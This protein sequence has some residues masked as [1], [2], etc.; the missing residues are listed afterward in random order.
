[1]ATIMT[2][3]FS[4]VESLELHGSGKVRDRGHAPDERPRT[5]EG[6][7]L[8][9]KQIRAR[10]R[11]RAK[12]GGR[13]RM[14]AVT[15]E[16]FEALYKPIEEWDLEELAKGRPRDINGKFTGATPNWIT[17]EVHEKAMELFQ[18]AIKGRMGEQ[19]LGALDT[20]SYILENDDVDHRGKPVIPANAKL[21]AAT[22]LL[23][24]V[25]GKP[26]QQIQQDISVKLQAILGSVMVN[27]NTALAPPSQGGYASQVDEPAYTL[28]HL[29]GHTIPMGIQET[30]EG[31]SQW[32]EDEDADLD[33]EAG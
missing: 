22:F 13:S 8:T 15:R 26:K 17:R 31:D 24:H 4:N 12:R 6:K 30:I 7:L 11:R 20:I 21:Q 9:P 16:E 2:V 10:A 18:S 25:V 19:S 33:Q 29:P 23:E 32:L 3:D 5:S 27:P 1:M 14:P 28:A